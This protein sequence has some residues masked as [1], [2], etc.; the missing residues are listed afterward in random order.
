MKKEDARNIAKK[1]V[2]KFRENE[3]I[4]TEEWDETRYLE[5]KISSALLTT[6]QEARREA[7][8]EAAKLAEKGPFLNST[9]C[10]TVEQMIAKAIR[11]RAEE[12]EK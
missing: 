8:E 2:A 5:Q 12:G 10:N 7:F 9:E 11:T 6:T 3:R 4:H 1:L